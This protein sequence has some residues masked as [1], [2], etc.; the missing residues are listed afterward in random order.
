MGPKLCRHHRLGSARAAHSA[1]LAGFAPPGSPKSPGASSNFFFWISDPNQKKTLWPL[2]TFL[3]KNLEKLAKGAGVHGMPG[4]RPTAHRPPLPGGPLQGLHPWAH[5][6][7]P[8]PPTIYFWISGP[9]RNKIRS[10]LWGLS[11]LKT[12][13]R[14]QRVQGF[15]ECLVRAPP[16]ID[17]HSPTAPLCHPHG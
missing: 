11:P 9:N 8:G 4:A 7:V 10:G 16:P 1:H 17:R 2:G 13:K 5:P 6:K 14:L 12:L 15:M 3:S